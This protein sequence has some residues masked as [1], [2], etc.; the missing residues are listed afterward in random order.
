MGEREEVKWR[1]RR[2]RRNQNE[3][4]EEDAEKEEQ[5]KDDGLSGDAADEHLLIDS[6]PFV[7]HCKALNEPVASV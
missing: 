7:F 6:G 2:S 4:K 3:R 5:R 1:E